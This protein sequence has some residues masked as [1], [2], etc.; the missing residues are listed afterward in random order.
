MFRV[1]TGASTHPDPRQAVAEAWRAVSSTLT[2]P[3]LVLVTATVGYDLGALHAAL[4]ETLGDIPFMGGTSCGGVM[5]DQGFFGTES[6]AL[7]MFAIQDDGGDYGIG[8]APLGQAP[9][10]AAQRAV[11]EALANAGCEGQLPTAVWMITSPGGE[12]D[13]VRGIADAVGEDVPLVGGSAA[14][15][16]I[17]GNWRQLVPAGVLDN[18]VC[19]AVLF[20]STAM[21]TSFHSGYDPTQHQGVI[22]RADGRTIF[23]IDGRPAAQV[24]NRWLDG[25]LD[26]VLDDGGGELLARTNL[27]PLGR[28]LRE[29]SGVPYYVLSHPE[30][31]HADGAMHLFT[32]FRTG[33]KLT[34]MTGTVDNLVARA[35]NVV[36]SALTSAGLTSND[37]DA[38]LIIFCAGCMMTVREQIAEVHANVKRALNGAP[39]MTV[40]TFG[41]QGRIAEVG[42]RHGNLMIAT[43]TFARAVGPSR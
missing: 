13:V 4:V 42:N 24:Y 32:E 36:C 20:P 1:V 27:H 26:D 12:E 39:F 35:G 29:V 10:G 25:A 37:A 18:H 16:T 5:T 9:R 6:G 43:L 19:V 38:A 33:E 22:T 8:Y 14:D 40:F 3:R 30:R 17:A 2:M 31:A 7:A 15:N 34:C 11:T 23:E 41:E 21:H 28:F